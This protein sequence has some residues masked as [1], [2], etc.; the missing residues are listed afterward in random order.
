MTAITYSC[1]ISVIGKADP[2]GEQYD[3]VAVPRIGE[4]IDG[5]GKVVDVMHLIKP[6]AFTSAPDIVLFVEEEKGLVTDGEE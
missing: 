6:T 2:L 4:R 1:R 3:F 5:V